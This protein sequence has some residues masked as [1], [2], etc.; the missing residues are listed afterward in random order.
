MPLLNSELDPF[1]DEREK[2][3]VG[4]HLFIVR[5]LDQVFLFSWRCVACLCGSLSRLT[6]F[7]A[8]GFPVPGFDVATSLGFLVW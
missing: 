1:L 3:R 6:G 5:L 4:I 8:F 7:F 2:E